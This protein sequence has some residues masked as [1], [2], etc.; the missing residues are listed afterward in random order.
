MMVPDGKNLR[1]EAMHDQLDIHLAS[2]AE[3]IEIYRNVHDVWGR[4]F[5]L[6]EHVQRR[7]ES[8][9]HNRAR[10]FVGCVAGRVVTSLGCYPLEF[11]LR[12]Q[13]VPGM[14]IGA[15]HTVEE[16]R[17]RG[18][19][20]R[21]FEW[22]E[23]YQR[24]Q[25]VKVSLLYSDIDPGYYARL[26]YLECPAHE[27]LIDV[28]Q[29]IPVS[30]GVA[31]T[32]VPFDSPSLEV[33]V[34]AYCAFQL[35][36]PFSIH[37]SEEYQDFL[38]RKGA[39]DRFY[40]VEVNGTRLGYIRVGEMQERGTDW[41]IRDW[42]MKNVD[43]CLFRDVVGA[44]IREG[45]KQGIERIDGWL[46]DVTPLS[47]MISLEKRREEITM[48]KPLVDDVN[49]DEDSLLAVDRFREIDHV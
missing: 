27:G 38:I 4:G 15:V 43:D 46:P 45:R 33:I 18:L 48:V 20:P 19:A 41:T 24:Q 40:H 5:S 30:C 28:T 14:A 21:L 6:D 8:V 39:Q 29:A 26:G 47:E 11:Q 34:G 3:R 32:L 22:V 44:V 36:V 42:A 49:L 31:V 25:G 2:D 10:W 1:A 37:R 17:G 35:S 16:F 23:S 9:Q 12:G 7:L 13:V